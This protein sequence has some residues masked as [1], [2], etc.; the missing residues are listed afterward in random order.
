LQQLLEATGDYTFATASERDIVDALKEKLCYV[1][2]SY[3][4]ELEVARAKNLVK[5]F[6]LPDGQVRNS[7]LS[8][9]RLCVFQLICFRIVCFRFAFFISFFFLSFLASWNS[10]LM[11]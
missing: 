4:K 11:H 10:C 9:L 8:M 6:G 7:F 2:L 3:E 1:A 5:S